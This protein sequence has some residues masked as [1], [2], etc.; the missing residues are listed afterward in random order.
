GTDC[1]TGRLTSRCPTDCLLRSRPL[2]GLF[3]RCATHCL[4]CGCLL[5]D[6]L[7]RGP[8]YCLLCWGPFHGLLGRG[9]LYSL[10]RRGSLNCFLCWG[11]FDGL[12]GRGPFFRG[13]CHRCTSLGALSLNRGEA[14]ATS[15]GRTHRRAHCRTDFF[16]TRD[17]R[18]V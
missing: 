8:L 13:Y 14:C 6:L 11:P 17:I 9:A 7:R 5:G 10:L 1:L 15:M 4:L 18:P 12:L 2:D 3:G 16:V